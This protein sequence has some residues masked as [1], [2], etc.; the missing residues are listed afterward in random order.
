[1]TMLTMRMQMPMMM[2]MMMTVIFAFISSYVRSPHLRLQMAWNQLRSSSVLL[3]RRAL[4]QRERL[5][6]LPV[7]RSASSWRCPGRPLLQLWRTTRRHAEWKGPRFLRSG[8][9]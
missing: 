8:P 7:R 3:P 6:C 2:L 1:M 4:V 9:G 5:F